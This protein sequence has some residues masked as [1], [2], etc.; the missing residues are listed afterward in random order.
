LD[1]VTKIADNNAD[2]WDWSLDAPI[3]RDENGV[4]ICG[5]GGCGGIEYEE[6]WIW[7]GTNLD[8]TAVLDAE[9]GARFPAFI[10]G[11]PVQDDTW[12]WSQHAHAT[13]EGRYY[14]MSGFLTVP[15][16]ATTIPAPAGLLL[17]GLGLAGLGIARHKRAA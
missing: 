9:L 6:E 4:S 10:A 1:G 15:E 3:D 14:A 2:L 5:A 7:T 13:D 16:N 12:I 17:F 11:L 8:G